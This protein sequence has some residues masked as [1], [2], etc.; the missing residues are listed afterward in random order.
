[1]GYLWVPEGPIKFV[2]KMPNI[3]KNIPEDVRTAILVKQAEI[4][5]KKKNGKLSQSYTLI[6]IVRE[7]LELKSTK[8][9]A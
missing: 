3:L 2:A 4:K 6:Q 8:P 5:S 7:W 9:I 1:M